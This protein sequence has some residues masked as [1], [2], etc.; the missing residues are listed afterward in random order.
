[1]NKILQGDVLEVLKTLP[2]ESVNC[3]ITSPPYW[4]LRDYGT[5]KWEGGKEKCDHKMPHQT[6]RH[7]PGDKSAT[8]KGS[9]PVVWSVCGKCGARKTD[10]QIGLEKTPEAYVEKIVNV[11]REVRR[12]LRKDGTLWLNLGDTYSAQRWTGAGKGQA[13]NRMKDSYRDINP[14]KESGLP[15]KNLVGIPWRVALALQ[16]DGWILRQDIIWNK[17]AV[18]PES[19]TDRCTKSHEYIFLLSKNPKYYFNNTLIKEPAVYGGTQARV[20]RASEEHKHAPTEKVNGIRDRRAGKGRIKYG[21][22]RKGDVGTGQES[23]VSIPEMRNKRSVWTVATRPFSGA[24]FAT[25]PEALIK[26]MVLAGCPPGG[27]CLDPFMGAGTTAVVAKQHGRDYLGVELNPAY[28]R[29]A[30]KRISSIQLKLLVN[31]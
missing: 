1:M 20:D 21:G 10:S 17:P 24:H 12:V 3:V 5:G 2:D 30:E 7:K 27:V 4:G 28:I 14:V 23:F 8:N 29:M 11:F 25:F 16:A 18:M 15:D 22:K 19:V 26:P 13:I 6:N 31:I 9:N